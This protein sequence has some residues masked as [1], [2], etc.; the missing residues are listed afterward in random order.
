[1]FALR[2]ILGAIAA[3]CPETAAYVAKTQS[4]QATQMSL[5]RAV[6]DGECC[7]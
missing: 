2:C 1:M 5:S 6:I 4:V 3:V 7:L